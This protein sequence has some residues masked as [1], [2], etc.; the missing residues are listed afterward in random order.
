MSVMIILSQVGY[1]MIE[2]G[3]IK[4]SNNTD[5]LLKNIIVM[6]ISSL[7]FFTFGYGFAT[8]AEGGLFG[9]LHFGGYEYEYTDYARWLYYYS[10]CVTM[11]QIATGS[12][13]ERT[14]LDNYFFFTFL[15]SALIFP[16]AL[17]WQWEDGWLANIGFED[18]A[19]AGIVHLAGGITGFIGT[20]LCGP[21]I[22]LYSFD[23]AKDYLLDDENFYDE[24]LSEDSDGDEHSNMIKDRFSAT[25]R[26]VS[27][28]NRYNT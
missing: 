15:T 24:E 6:A 22:G 4:I 10:L 26:S 13:A 1:M 2:I 20:Y 27:V 19:G 5:L 3:T 23:G 14:S 18:F 25:N 16:L 12:I 8:Q 7:T 17:A 21:R 11:A 28:S 9:Q